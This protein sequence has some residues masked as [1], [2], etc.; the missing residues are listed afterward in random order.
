MIKTKKQ[1]FIVIG[2]F[3]LVMLLGT[4]TY[5][6][7]NYTRTGVANTI[8]VGRIAFRTNQTDTISLTNL[9][10]IDPTETGIM[11]D[12]TKVGTL[13]I[14]IEGD[15]DYTGG[16]E[17]LVSSV[18]TNIYTST[19]KTVPLS[20]NV[21]VNSDLGTSN[22]NYFTAREN[23][24]ASIYKKI[25]GDTLVGDEMLL[26]GFIKP[27][28][29]SGTT[30]GIDGN[31]TIKA[32]LDK[33]KILISDT[34]NNG[35]T[36]TDNMGTPNLLAQGK[37]VLTTTEWN[38]LQSS[39]LSFKVKVEANQGIWVKGSLEE[40]MKK[41][42]VMDNINS[43]YVD[44]TTPGI[45]FAAVSGDTNGKGV[46]TRAGTQNATNPIM[47]YRGE[48]D[49][50]NVIFANKCWKTVRTTDTGGVKLIYNGLPGNVYAQEPIAEANYTIDTTN[51]DSRW[52]FDSNDKTWNIEIN[53]NTHPAIEFTVPAGN[54]Y[55]MVLTG[56]SG[57]SCGGTFSFYLNGATVNN[58]GNGGGASMNLEYAYGQLTATDVIKMD[59]AG[60][61]S[62]TCPITFKL[63][64]NG[65][66]EQIADYGCSNMKT[67][68]IISLNNSSSFKYTTNSNSPA[69]VGYMY[70]DIYRYNKQEPTS[71]AYFG[72]SFE[73]GDFDNNG[74]SEY[75][76]LAGTISTTLDATHH[77]TCNLTT[78][79]G[80]C[81]TLRF[82]YSNIYY[83]NLTG[84]IGI[85]EAIKR[86]QTNTNDSI[87]KETIDSWYASNM[88]D[89]TDKLEDTI[90]CNDRS[91]GK[92][93]GW[94]A[95]GEWSTSN[96]N[97]Y[98][99][100]FGP[101]ERSN[102]SSPTSSTKNQPSLECLNKNDRFTV[103]NINGN[104]KLDYPVALLTEDEIVL[105]G[106]VANEE[107]KYY[108][109]NGLANWTMSPSY[110]ST[111]NANIFITSDGRVVYSDSAS[112]PFGLRPAISIKPGQLITS[113]AG[114][115]IDPYIIE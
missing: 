91:F 99:L 56:T 92:A 58:Y 94:S 49:D 1:M 100:L 9:F 59:Y 22:A 109:K 2:V 12:E 52:T 65:D 54:N 62:S 104:K 32:Y 98:S 95:T 86:M 77:Y 114:T 69:Y 27:N 18:N 4:V 112:Y 24:N 110:F 76:L 75:R 31:I 70:G 13:E 102:I 82:Y 111:Y 61:S 39:S 96:H 68:S 66:G 67:D 107:S 106:G 11:D 90:W 101:Y 14:D 43:T 97:L 35:E 53:D 36:P 21:T 64:M 47:Y 15:T 8:R 20:L 34:Y 60:N 105:A 29:T 83:I 85:D 44:N 7:F 40:I 93:N 50:N 71:G 80:T 57:S 78:Q 38:A 45:N 33:N 28:T 108:I 63:K 23:T 37:T 87:A 41:S 26:V 73:Y 46:Y 3:A 10:P 51:T 74:V 5:A 103:N 6:F 17:Y 48:V 115:A 84:G 55:N 81:T 72:S 42:A 16:I 113:G 30:E 79:T 25:V 19:G 88:N 89:F